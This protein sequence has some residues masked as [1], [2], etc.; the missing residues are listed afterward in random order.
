MQ[1][2]AASTPAK[3][4]APDWV[5]RGISVLNAMVGD[6]LHA[7]GNPLAIEMACHHAGHPLR[8]TRA[9]LKRAYPDATAK[10]CVLVHGLGCNEGIWSYAAASGE[11]GLSYGSMLRDRLR[12]TPIYVRYNT[13]LSVAA[14]GALLTTLLARL[15]AAWPVRT[16]EIV[17]IGHSMGGLLLRCACDLARQR[18]TAWVAKVKRA[19]YLGT[20]HDGA[21]LE[22]IAQLAAA[23][24][25]RVPNLVTRLIADVM[26]V[27][28]RGV[29]DLGFD[30][31]RNRDGNGE[32]GI[33]WLASAHH[34]LIAGTVTGDPR[35]PAALILG[36]ALVRPP[37]AS[38]R[39]APARKGA[40]PAGDNISLFSGIRHLRLAH[41]PRVYAQI[42][43]W[44]AGP[45]QAQ[46]P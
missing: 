14:N 27:R 35:H 13:G 11:R 9:A 4:S 2:A 5:D 26:N 32:G 19:I 37:P 24:L 23:T 22:K 29:K 25:Q 7:R 21:D 18:R 33:P 42:E 8:L 43:R 3:H 1:A 6:H 34:H 17:L 41:D 12:Y 30:V 36:D 28:S 10:I 16:A 46:T 39:M 20:P 31:S 44:C 15:H 40:R 38:V 45:E